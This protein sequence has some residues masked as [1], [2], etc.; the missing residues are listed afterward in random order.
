MKLGEAKGNLLVSLLKQQDLMVIL[1][2]ILCIHINTDL[3]IKECIISTS[4]QD[5]IDDVINE[6]K[7]KVVKTVNVLTGFVFDFGTAEGNATGKFMELIYKLLPMM[8]STII[9]YCKTDRL[10]I[11]KHLGVI[12]Y[13]CVGDI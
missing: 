8:L 13:S 3:Q 11:T 2:K 12:N 9:K 10:D 1:M 7:I 4:G 5:R 6:I